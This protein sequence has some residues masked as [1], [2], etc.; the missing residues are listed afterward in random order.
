MGESE[1]T[2]DEEGHLS[3]FF[4]DPFCQ[5]AGKAP[6]AV[7]FLGGAFLCVLS[8]A[9]SRNLHAQVLE[10]RRGSALKLKPQ[11]VKLT[12]MAEMVKLVRALAS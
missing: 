12:S 3:H 9:S 5:G 10:S 7:F 8:L 11:S 1:T 6:N 2:Y 4:S